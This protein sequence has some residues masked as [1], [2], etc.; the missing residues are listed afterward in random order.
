MAGKPAID[1]AALARKLKERLQHRPAVPTHVLQRMPTLPVLQTATLRGI[2]FRLLGFTFGGNSKKPG[3]HTQ[4]CAYRNLKD[5]KDRFLLVVY[6]GA[7]EGDV[8]AAQAALGQEV[9]G[10]KLAPFAVRALEG[11][12]FQVLRRILQSS[13]P[14]QWYWDPSASKSNL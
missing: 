7:G 8:T 10:S 13:F 1:K 6:E 14:S 4:I 9:D 12:T 3:Y 5:D 2:S 11:D